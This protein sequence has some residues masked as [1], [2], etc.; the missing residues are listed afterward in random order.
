VGSGGA[1]LVDD[2]GVLQGALHATAND[3]QAS[4]IAP[5]QRF[6]HSCAQ[7]TMSDELRATAPSA[8]YL[9]SRSSEIAVPHDNRTH[10]PI[11]G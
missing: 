1:P 3:P 7:S 5:S 10:S 11:S 6:V 8:S 2:L 9:W 4:F